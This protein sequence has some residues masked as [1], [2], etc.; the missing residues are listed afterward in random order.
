MQ[1]YR[2]MQLQKEH[3]DSLLKYFPKDNNGDSKF[4]KDF[5]M[6][7]NARKDSVDATSKSVKKAIKNNILPLLPI[8]LP[9]GCNLSLW[10]WL[11]RK[12][13]FLRV[14]AEKRAIGC[15]QKSIYSAEIKAASQNPKQPKKGW[16]IQEHRDKIIEK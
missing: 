13:V 7:F 15:V 2:N 6:L 12:C 3:L 1:V 10:H 5:D 8:N 9:S 11:I 14:D 4:T 16:K